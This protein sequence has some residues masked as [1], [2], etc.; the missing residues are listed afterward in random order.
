MNILQ[1]MADGELFGRWFQRGTL[2]G[3]SWRTWRVFLAALFGLGLDTE[4]RAIYKAFSGRD[5]VPTQQASES[6]LICGRRSGK[7]LVSALIAVFL[8]VFR[9]YESVLAPGE[10]ATIM[11]IA[12]DRKQARVVLGYINGFFDTIEIL[13]QMIASRTK[14]SITLTNRVRIEVHTASFRA[15]RGYSVAC[16]ILDEVAFFPSGDS[17]SPD[18]EIVTALRPAMATI[19]G[20][21]LLG[22]SSPYAKRGVLYEAF[23]SHYGK[24]GAPALVWRAPTASMNPTVSKATIAM[25]YMR[26]SAAADSEYG[27]NF[28]N[29]ISGFISREIVEARVIRGR[30]ELP[31]VAGVTYTAFV[32]PSGGQADAMT[33]GICHVERG[34]GVLDLLRESPAPFSPDAVCKE[35]AEVLKRY[36]I[37]AVSGDKY[38][39]Q[40]PREGFSK[41]GIQ[42]RCAERTRSEIYLELLPALMSGTVELLDNKKLVEQL[43]GLERRTARSGRDSIDHSPGA[44]DDLCNSAAG[45]LVEVLKGTGELG[46]VNF[47]KGL[48]A[49][50]FRLDDEKQ[51]TPGEQ[52]AARQAAMKTEAEI[53]GLKPAQPTEENPPCEKCG[54]SCV[55]KVAG[56]FRC[57]Q[58][59]AQRW[60]PDAMRPEQ[61]FNRNDFLSGRIASRKGW[62]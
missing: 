10:V 38:A 24:P 3:D 23:T 22:I 1:A 36:G 5:D 48:A 28:R 49:G 7:S 33:L 50:I 15:L 56:Q 27:A 60:V 41:Y 54:A 8:A 55:T 58:C 59:G 30:Y 62:Q 53:L 40:W 4:A 39:G 31:R 43:I 16:A 6:W 13:G 34:V 25:A 11:V 14:E 26:D 32:D 21:L 51:P 20:S 18:E 52:L 47:L 12:A 35:F 37:A 61:P 9:S 17:A 57:Q 44:H 29:D 42:Y 46:F 19:P 45:C 2:R